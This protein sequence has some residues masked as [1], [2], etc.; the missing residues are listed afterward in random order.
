LIE[1]VDDSLRAVVDGQ[2]LKKSDP[3]TQFQ[4]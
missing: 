2:L 4:F 3:R 1:I